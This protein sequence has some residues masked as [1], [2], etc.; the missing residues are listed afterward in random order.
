MRVTNVIPLGCSLLFLV[1]TVN[2]AETLKA[3]DRTSYNGQDANHELCHTPLNGL[4]A[5]D[6]TSYNGQNASKLPGIDVSAVHGVFGG[7]TASDIVSPV[8][9]LLLLFLSYPIYTSGLYILPA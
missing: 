7:W 3:H 1:G 8:C 4:K 2:S 6:R 5:Y 9:V